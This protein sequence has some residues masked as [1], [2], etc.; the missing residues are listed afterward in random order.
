[1]PKNKVLVVDDDQTIC[2]TL[3]TALS[4]WGYTPVEARTVSDAIRIF[5]TELPEVV[6]L[7]INLPDG[8]GLKVLREM[9]RRQ[10]QAVV[11]LISTDVFD[12]NTIGAIRGGAYDYMGK[13][14]NLDELE[15]RIHNGIEAARK[16]YKALSEFRTYVE[17]N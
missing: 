1:M 16:L 15:V 8:S 2:W 13:H 14:L 10:P 9:K 6:L 4:G 3:C 5:N 7:D 17:N 11:I 12:E